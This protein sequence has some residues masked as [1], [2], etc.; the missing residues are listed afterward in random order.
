MKE[1][2]LKVAIYC[3]VGNPADAG[4]SVEHTSGH[5]DI[6]ENIIIAGQKAMSRKTRTEQVFQGEIT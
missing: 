6:R 5:D 4:M 2:E 1:Q 3:R